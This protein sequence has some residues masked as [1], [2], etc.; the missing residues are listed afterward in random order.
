ME[1]S[2]LLKQ[3][4]RWLFA[5]SALA[6]IALSIDLSTLT[7]IISQVKLPWLLAAFAIVLLI[8]ILSAIR[9]HHILKVYGIHPTLPEIIRLTF[10]SNSLGHVLPGGLGADIIRGHQVIKNHG[11]MPEVVATITLDRILGFYS[12]LFM[13]LAA[14]LLAAGSD[15][16]QNIQP[17]LL[18]SNILFLTGTAVLLMIKSKID[19]SLPN[20]MVKF[21]KI[22]KVLIRL[23]NALGNISN[24]QQILLPIFS[25]SLLVQLARCFVF[26]CIYTSL[27]QPLDLIYFLIFIPLVFVIM[28]IPV[29][30][31]GIGLREGAL[32]Y[33]FTPLGLIAEINISAGLLFHALQILALIPGLALFLLQRKPAHDNAVSL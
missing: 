12:M 19:F 16:L 7:A 11:A 14:S 28:M 27:S 29:S 24:L 25:L 13:A 20:A 22:K 30:I 2:K 1:K 6:I 10:V 18:F 33:F 31:G 9:W 32:V 21:Y 26:Y 8:R 5:I 23:T 4:A 3:S 15:T 17:F